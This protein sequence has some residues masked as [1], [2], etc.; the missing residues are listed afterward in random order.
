MIYQLHTPPLWQKD[1]IF[2]KQFI[3]LTEQRLCTSPYCTFLCTRI[4][5]GSQGYCI[6]YERH[7]FVTTELNAEADVRS[8]KNVET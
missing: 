2:L 3:N 8:I 1:E 5:Q 6:Y 4:K 7:K